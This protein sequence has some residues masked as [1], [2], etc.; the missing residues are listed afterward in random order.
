VIRTAVP[1]RIF[2]YFLKT[3][4]PFDGLRSTGALHWLINIHYTQLFH[5]LKIT[6]TSYDFVFSSD[7]V[8][9]RLGMHRILFLPDIQL[10]QKPDTGYPVGARY[11]YRIS[12]RIL[13]FTTIFLFKY[14]INVK[15]SFNN[16]RPLQALNKTWS[17]SKNICVQFFSF[18]IWIKTTKKFGLA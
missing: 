6:K 7:I 3:G 1:Y 12:D 10:I 4:R 18:L 2:R 11:W 17:S 16:Y 15:K 5:K 8:K 13:G 14:Q 9:F